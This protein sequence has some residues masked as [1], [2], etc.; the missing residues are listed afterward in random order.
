MIPDNNL[1]GREIN[2]LPKVL[3]VLIV[4]IAVSSFLKASGFQSL[5]YESFSTQFENRFHIISNRIRFV[6]SVGKKGGKPKNNQ[7]RPKRNKDPEK[8]QAR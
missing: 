3:I 8:T 7:N 1:R 4:L 5:K 2:I 6:K